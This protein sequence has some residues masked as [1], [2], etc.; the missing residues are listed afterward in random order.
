M[1]DYGVDPFAP[2]PPYITLTLLTRPWAW[3]WRPLLSLTKWVV[4][5]CLSTLYEY[6]AEMGLVG[7][8]GNG[9]GLAGAAKYGAGAGPGAGPGAGAGA[10]G[11]KAVI[12]ETQTSF[13]DASAEVMDEYDWSMMN[14]EYM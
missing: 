1:V 3:L 11:W 9:N 14:D 2:R 10:G 4:R 7:G 6:L 5:L 8:V 13:A 12:R